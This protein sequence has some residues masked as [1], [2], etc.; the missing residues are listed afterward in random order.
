MNQGKK[1]EL[2]PFFSS[3]PFLK[4]KLFIYLFMC[5]VWAEHKRLVN[6]EKK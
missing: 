6:R 1:K 3:S 5:V 2:S 4:N